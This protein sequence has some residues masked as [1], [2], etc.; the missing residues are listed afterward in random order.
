MP[1]PDAAHLSAPSSVLVRISPF[2]SAQKPFDIPRQMDANLIL[3][4]GWY[5]AD[6]DCGAL[7]KNGEVVRVAMNEYNTSRRIKIV[8]GHRYRASCAA[9][10]MNVLRVEDLGVEPNNSFKPNPHQGGA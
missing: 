4:S 6:F 10:T 7:T 5:I 8:A 1:A 3:A 2:R 9:E